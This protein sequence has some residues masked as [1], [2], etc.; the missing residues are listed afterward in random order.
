[1]HTKIKNQN[2]WGI[3]SMQKL[4][5]ALVVISRLNQGSTDRNPLVPDRTG[6]RKILVIQDQLGV[7]KI[8]NLGPDRIRTNKILESSG[9][10]GPVWLSVDPWTEYVPNVSNSRVTWLIQ[11]SRWIS[12]ISKF[13]KNLQK[14]IS[15][16]SQ[17][18]H[19]KSFSKLFIRHTQV[20]IL[21]R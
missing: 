19:T 20:P 7:G 17:K 18:T 11:L 5:M 3:V 16:K 15:K 10:F 1:M 14:K 4:I 9:R 6:T 13:F 8:P 12:K 21:L 2:S